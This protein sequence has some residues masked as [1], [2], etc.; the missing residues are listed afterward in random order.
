MK[1]LFIVTGGCG[2]LGNTIVHK[3]LARGERV[4]VL[5]FPGETRKAL[6]DCPGAEFFQGDVC[7]R[8]SLGPIF[9]HEADETL[10][11]IHTAAI[12]SI[13]AKVSPRLRAVNVGGVKNIVALCLENPGTRLI[14]VSSVHALPEHPGH[15]IIRESDQYHAAWVTGAYA[16][17][18]AEA[19]QYVLNAVKFKGLDATIVL[20]S[21]ILGPGDYGANNINRTI[22]DCVTGKLH[23]LVVGGYDLIDVRDVAE[24]CISAVDKGVTGECY[25]LAN[26]HFDWREV[27]GILEQNDP[28]VH[29]KHF[30]S[31][32]GLRPLAPFLELHAK[33]HRTQPLFTGYSIYCMRS[34]D[35]F[36]ARKARKVLGLTTRPMEETLRDTARWER[37]KVAAMNTHPDVS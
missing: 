24:G 11:V 19:A 16:K 5:V 36:S 13:A 8:T 7:D 25:I 22:R 28:T 20:P 10:V 3:L 35:N 15:S 29:V 6:D 32:A 2:H 37:E 12:I 23:T 34:N 30:F 17:T 27:A 21:G 14:H 4:R 18:K 31:P 33:V 9:A 1:R 26:R